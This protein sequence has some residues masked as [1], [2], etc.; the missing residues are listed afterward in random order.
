MAAFER[1]IELVR[2]IPEVEYVKVPEGGH[3][4]VYTYIAS[5]DEEPCYR[6]IRAENTVI[7]EFPESELDFHIRFFEG[8]SI[9]E[10]AREPGMHFDPSKDG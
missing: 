8:H 6:V 5:R 10:L 1:F 2:L 4:E 9:A 7:R 3:P